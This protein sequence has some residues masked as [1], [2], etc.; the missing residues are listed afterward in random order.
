MFQNT[1]QTTLAKRKAPFGAVWSLLT[2]SVVFLIFALIA[3]QIGHEVASTIRAREVAPPA[4]SEQL[5]APTP[6]VPFVPPVV[7]LPP[8]NKSSGVTNPTATP[9]KGLTP[10]PNTR[11]PAPAATAKPAAPRASAP[12]PKPTTKPS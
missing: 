3:Y 4:Q 1:T 6:D 2:F 10:P 5:P 12:Q 11:R 7:A 9:S 8:S